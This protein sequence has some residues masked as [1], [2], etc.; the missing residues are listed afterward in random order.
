[1][2]PR[3]SVM[4]YDSQRVQLY[5]LLFLACSFMSAMGVGTLFSM[6]FLSVVVVEL[7]YCWHR[8]HKL[9]Y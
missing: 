4:E 3:K 7:A 6:A 1:M 8:Y 2:K 5:A 9:G